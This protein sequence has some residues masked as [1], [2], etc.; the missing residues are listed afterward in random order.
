V[1]ECP[2][3]IE[4]PHGLM[5]ELRAAVAYGQQAFTRGGMEV[6]GV[7]F[8]TRSEGALSIRAWRPIACE[9]ANG[10]ALLLSERD[11]NELKEF[12]EEAATLP[13]LAGAEPVGWFL[14]HTRSEISLRESD[15]NLYREFFPAASDIVLVLRPGRHGAARAGF[16]FRSP[17]GAIR[18][19]HSLFEFNIE[20]EGVRPSMPMERT[21]PPPVEISAPH[22]R[23][24]RGAAPA[25]VDTATAWV[26]TTRSDVPEPDPLA[27][28]PANDEMEPVLTGKR[29][30]RWIALPVAA[31][32]AIGWLYMAR[33]R[34]PEPAE[35]PIEMTITDRGG[36]LVVEWDHSRPELLRVRAGEISVTDA[37]GKVSIALTAAE[38]QAGSF[39]WTRKSGDVRISLRFDGAGKPLGASA[40]FLGAPPPQQ[41]PERAAEPDSAELDRLRK[42][43][44]ELRGEIDRAKARADQAE[45]AVRVLR[46]RLDATE[47]KK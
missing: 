39:T 35:I 6:G 10:P 11:R 7:L 42:E 24:R 41:R 1:P 18:S 12:L 2:F 23:R 34:A 17:E 29:S 3:S 9:H 31:L 38:V 47:T 46:E 4:Y 37:G 14:S 15:L 40:H 43:N 20:R 33:T 16:F 25:P 27:T 13:D 26:R 45:T 32:V 8:G 22:E 44:I 21:P 19:D 36:Q 28:S 30:W 5:Q